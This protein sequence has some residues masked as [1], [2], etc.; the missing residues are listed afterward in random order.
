MPGPHASTGPG[1]GIG[2]DIEEVRGTLEYARHLRMALDLLEENLPPPM[3]A[4][5]S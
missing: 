1:T 2:P 3:P 4:T 5:G